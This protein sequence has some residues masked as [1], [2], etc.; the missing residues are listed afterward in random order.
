MENT[1][2][3]NESFSYIKSSFGFLVKHPAKKQIFT[4]LQIAEAIKKNYSLEN[5]K[6]KYCYDFCV[7]ND[8][9]MVI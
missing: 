9:E 6:T 1:A 7:N 3:N 4:N 2:M 5:P 8:F